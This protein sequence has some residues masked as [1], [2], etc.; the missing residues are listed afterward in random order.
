MDDIALRHMLGEEEVRTR[1]FAAIIGYL[2][3]MG[4]FGCLPRNAHNPQVSS[5]PSLSPSSLLREGEGE[6]ANL[7]R[8]I[9]GFGTRSTQCTVRGT[10]YEL[11]TQSDVAGAHWI[12]F[13]EHSPGV[14]TEAS[15]LIE[16]VSICY[17]AS[18]LASRSEVSP[19]SN[20]SISA[21]T[22][23]RG[24]DHLRCNYLADA[25]EQGFFQQGMRASEAHR[26]FENDLRFDADASG[27]GDFTGLVLVGRQ[28]RFSV[29]LKLEFEGKP[30]DIEEAELRGIAC[31]WRS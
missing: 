20:S 21:W 1:R 5:M 6:R 13:I 16:P 11:I 30:G 7:R 24:N 12:C 23:I 8:Q 18:F 28:G 3:I 10:R 19:I 26:F 15:R 14:T 29:W 22:S 9:D 31:E 25:I 2:L 17:V 4:S 27:S